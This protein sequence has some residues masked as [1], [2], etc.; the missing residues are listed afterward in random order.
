MVAPAGQG[1]AGQT[2]MQQ[3][4]R[5]TGL[6]SE[7]DRL[8]GELEARLDQLT[9]STLERLGQRVPQWLTETAF[10]REQI[11]DF[12]RVSLRTQLRAFARD[13]LPQSCPELDAAAARVVARV[14]ELELFTH[15]YRS[16]Q[17]ALWEAWFC[18]IEDD[19]AKLSASERRQCLARG[20]DFFFRYADLLGDY[21]AEVYREELGKLRANGEQRRFHA[22]RE[23]LEGEAGADPSGALDLDL[24]QHHLGLLAWEE[25]GELAAR[26]LAE[27]LGRRL[28][29]VAPIER[30]WWGWISGT[31]PFDREAQRTIERFQAP[32]RSAI[33][34][35]M[36]EFG[37]PGFRVTHRQ[38]Q[39]ARQL[40]PQGLPSLTRYADVAVEALASENPEEARS[41]LN[42]ELGEL[43]DDSRTSRQIRETLEAYFAAGH[44]AASAAAT[45]GIHQQTVANRL[46]AAEERLGHP[47]GARRVELELALRLRQA[48]RKA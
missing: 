15:G 37:L 46:R 8:A 41:F 19:S 11:A 16:A 35:G 20:S 12:T 36:Q 28:L 9:E 44:N 17:M 42:R 24:A 26:Q 10:T 29:I 34:L 31:R 21:V 32:E 18:L 27:A 47:I 1:P 39:R 23:L 14:G 2:T 5:L 13:T 48:F 33:A 40:A 3:R 7:F 6:M 25:Q 4:E 38:A 45:L 43:G 22:I 30:T